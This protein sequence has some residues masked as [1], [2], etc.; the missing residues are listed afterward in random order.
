MDLDTLFADDLPAEARE[1]LDAAERE[2]AK[3]RDKAERDVRKVREKA[4]LQVN[5]IERT[6]EASIEER[7]RELI[8]ALKPLQESY[9]REGKLDEA[10]AI[11][12]RIRQMRAG[13]LGVQPGPETLEGMGADIGKSFLFEVTG[14]ASGPLWGTDLYTADS[15]LSGAAVHAGVLRAGERGVVRVTLVDTEGESFRGC[16]RNGVH[17]ESWDEYEF[18]YRVARP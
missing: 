2:L 9:A 13:M 1:L 16:R 11:R 17:S 5:V 14:S 15:R 6:A 7:G 18:G 10:L 8:A 4:D 3:I 12:D